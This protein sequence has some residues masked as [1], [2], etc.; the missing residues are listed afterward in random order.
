M[1]AR[2]RLVRRSLRERFVVTMRSGEAFEGLLLEVDDRTLVLAD[3]HVLTGNARH[4]ADGLLYL[5]RL[6]V[7]YMQKPEASG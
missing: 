7:A 4:A 1:A 2:D 3:G 6:E 5:P